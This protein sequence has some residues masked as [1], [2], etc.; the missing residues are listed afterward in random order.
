MTSKA[1]ERKNAPLHTAAV[2][3]FELTLP[4][5][6]SVCVAGSFNDW[7]PAVSPMVRLGDGR[8]VKC[9]SLPPGR[10]EYRFLV[11]GQWVADPAA[12]EL[13]PNGD[14]GW[15]AVLVVSSDTGRNSFNRV[16]PGAPF[17]GRRMLRTCR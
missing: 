7:R 5:A 12:K 6:K 14:G 8:W 9:L 10:Y 3:R 15:N 16:P 11:D 4:E 1:I 2:V 13:V 17:S